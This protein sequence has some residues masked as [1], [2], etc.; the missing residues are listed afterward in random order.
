[1]LQIVDEP[2]NLRDSRGTERLHK[3]RIAAKWTMRAGE[4]FH[5]RG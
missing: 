1:V 4:L 5:G 2:V 3:R